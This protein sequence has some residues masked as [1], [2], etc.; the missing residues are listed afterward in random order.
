MAEFL[1]SLLPSIP[2]AVDSSAAQSHAAETG[3]WQDVLKAKV[4][5]GISEE[6]GESSAIVICFKYHGLILYVF[7]VVQE[8]TV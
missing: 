2:V 3:L 8:L 7:R 1:L 4:T 5:P 6:K